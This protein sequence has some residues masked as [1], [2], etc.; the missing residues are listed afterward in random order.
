MPTAPRRKTRT[1]PPKGSWALAS[2]SACSRRSP[3][4]ATRNR[5][6]SSVRPSRSC[7]TGRDCS[8]RHRPGPA[9]PRPSPC[10][11]LPADRDRRRGSGSHVGARRSCRPASSRCRSPKR[12]TPTARRLGV[13]VVPVYGGQPIGQQ[14]RGLRRGV[15]VV[16]ATPGRAVDH[17][18]RGSLGLDDVSARSCSTRPTRCSTWASRRTS[19]RSST[20]TPAERQTALFSAT[21]SP[22]DPRIAKRHLRDPARVRST[23]SGRPATARR[24]SARSAYVVRR[25]GQA[26]GPVPHPRR[27]GPDLGPGVRADPRRGRRSRRGAERPR[28]RRRRRSTAAS[29]RRRATGSWAASATAPWTCSSRRTWRRAGSTSTTSATSS[30]STCRPTPTRTSIASAGPGEPAARASRSRSWSHASTGCCATSRRRRR[31]SSRSPACRRVADLR[32]RR[33]RAAP[34]RTCA[35]RSSPATTTASAA[36]SSR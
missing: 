21:I 8:P 9:R 23:P 1:R 18:N 30:T 4:S 12:S 28:A 5:P 10:R 2:T 14:L 17:L 24:G 33:R 36:S 34:R 35:R 27:R 32:E 13:R 6:R 7:S 3:T 19:T 20:S 11:C 31:R 25:V 29:P 26:R 15:D 16:V 22:V